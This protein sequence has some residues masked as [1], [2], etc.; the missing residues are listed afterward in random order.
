MRN[1]IAIG[2]ESQSATMMIDSRRGRWV[3]VAIAATVG[4]AV[5]SP[6]ALGLEENASSVTP[7]S[8]PWPT[9][10]NGYKGQR[11]SPLAE[12]TV[13]NAGALKEVCRRKVAD[14]GSFQTG[15]VVVDGS[16]Y[17]TTALDTFSVDPTNCSLRWKSS[18]PLEEVQVWAA[19]RGVAVMNGRVFRGTVDG[20]LLALN[21]KT[22][23]LIWKDVVGDP[24]LNEFVP[25][26]P[27]AWNGLVITGTSGGDFG[28]RGRILAYD[29]LTGRE[30]WHFTT[31]PTGNEVG[32]ETWERKPSADIGG[33]GTW[34]SF[35][36]DVIN[37]EVFIPVGDAAPTNVPESRPGANLFTDSVVVLDARTGALKWWYQLD[38]NDA[39]DY[40]LGAAPML[41]TTSEGN[42][43]FAAAGKDGYVHVVD[44]LTHR[45][46]FKTALTTIENEGV[47]PSEKETKFCPG[48]LGGTE[49]NGPA[50]DPSSRTLLVGAVDWCSTVKATGETRFIKGEG[51][52]LH[53]GTV[54]M[55]MDPPPSGWISALDS[56]SGAIKWKYHAEAP[57]FAGVTATAGGIVLTGDMADIF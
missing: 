21:A 18:Y 3:T 40:D 22:G 15:P 10:N 39:H 41:Y 35:A 12:I 42:D 49:W 44:R 1:A 52:F 33:G 17:L 29:A 6:L 4:C 46:R 24:T 5:L 45:L 53:G 13:K 8:S 34:S 47:K 38:P 11:F 7:A 56:D 16:M 2:R 27:V 48:S 51:R 31:I 14:G 28:I 54:T 50:L 25:S 36:L 9:Y 19:N 37:G 23:A 20:R 32:A 26:A 30:V 55:L 57:I 43:V